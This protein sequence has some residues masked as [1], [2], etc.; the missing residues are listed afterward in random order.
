ML[1]NAIKWK[2]E[3]TTSFVIVAFVGSI[4][5]I[6]GTWIELNMQTSPPVQL[7]YKCQYDPPF[8]SKQ[9]NYTGLEQLWFHFTITDIHTEP[10]GIYSVTAYNLPTP[11]INASGQKL[12]SKAVQAPEL[13]NISAVR[14]E[15][16]V[17][18]TFKSHSD[19]NYYEIRLLRGT[20]ILNISKVVTI[21]PNFEHCEPVCDTVKC[22]VDCEGQFCRL[23]MGRGFSK[24]SLS[25]TSTG[26]MG[27]LVVYPPIDAMFQCAVMAL[28]DFL[29]SHKELEIC[30][31]MWQRGSLAEQGMLRWLTSQI[32]RADKV[33]VIFPPGCTDTGIGTN[34]CLNP[35]PVLANYTVPASA[36]ELYSLALNLVMMDAYDPQLCS[37]FWVV[38]LGQAGDPPTVPVALQSCRAFS[39]PRDLEKLHYELACR[40]GEKWSSLSCRFQPIPCQEASRKFREALLNLDRSRMDCSKEEMVRLTD[41]ENKL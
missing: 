37:K 28:A 10:N 36:H 24:P 30:I 17:E 27:V 13:W 14:E 34:G 5:S 18:V 21:S 9:A 31:D 8:T 19:S 15:D 22:K 7:S 12:K 11:P 25:S 33:L 32:D 16:E 3:R 1:G 20:N 23:C 38:H 39:L 26:L 35:N 6:H 4:H 29:H 2:P 41:V 40:H